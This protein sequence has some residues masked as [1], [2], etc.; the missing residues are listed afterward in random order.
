MYVCDS[1]RS[2]TNNCRAR[3][4][5]NDTDTNTHT[6]TFSQHIPTEAGRLQATKQ[7]ISRSDLAFGERRIEQPRGGVSLSGLRLLAGPTANTHSATAFAQKNL[8]ANATEKERSWKKRI[9]TRKAK[10]TKRTCRFVVRTLF[11]LR[12]S[13]LFSAFIGIRGTGGLECR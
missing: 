13:S 6:H 1:M 2:A 3:D 10:Q 7:L 8:R 12:C 11:V 9:K 4:R 5:K